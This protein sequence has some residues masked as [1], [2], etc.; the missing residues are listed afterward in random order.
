MGLFFQKSKP[1]TEAEVVALVDLLAA[2]G[3]EF[4]QF[5]EDDYPVEYRVAYVAQK[6]GLIICDT[7]GSFRFNNDFYLTNKGRAL[8]GLPLLKERRG[9]S[10]LIFG[11]YVIN[12]ESALTMPGKA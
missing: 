10:R 12:D 4:S 8:K 3:G 11:R 1:V 2:A 9:L 5:S 7:Q 6:Q